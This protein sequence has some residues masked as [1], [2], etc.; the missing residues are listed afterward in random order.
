MRYLKH[1]FKLRFISL[2]L[3]LGMF[4]VTRH[5]RAEEAQKEVSNPPTAE[6]MPEVLVTAQQDNRKKSYKVDKVQSSKYTENL[7]DIPQTITVV[8][9]SVIQAQNATTLRDT[10]RNVPGISMQAGEGGTP[11]GDQF[12]IRGFSSRTDLYVDGVRDFGGYSRDPFNFEQVEVVKGPASSYAGRGSTG[13]SVNMVSKMPEEESFYRATAGW[14]TANYERTTVDVNQSMEPAG[15]SGAAARFN[16]MWQDSNV[17]GR[18]VTENERFGIAPSVAFGLDSDTRVKVGYF[19]MNQNNTPDY[20]VPWVPNT[21]NAL[22]EYRD[23][24]SPESWHK[25]YGLVDRDYDDTDTSML[26]GEIEHDFN[27]N[28]TLRNLTRWGRNSRDS[29]I[30]APRFTTNNNSTDIRRTDWKSRDQI[31]HV[32]ANQTDLTSLFSTFDLEHKLV[33]GVELVRETEVNHQRLA[34]GPASSNTSLENP[35]PNDSYRENIQRTGDKAETTAHSLALYGFDTIDLTDWL[36]VNGGI[37]WDY[38]RTRHTP[39][40][41]ADELDRLDRQF[42]WNAGINYKP[43]PYGSIYFGYG[44]AFNPSA[45]G[46]TLSTG[47]TSA[48]NLNSD[49]ETSRTFELGTKWDLFQERLSVNGAVFYTEKTNSRTQD[50]ADATDIIVNEGVQRVQGFEL[51]I[52]GNITEKW[53][54]FAAYTAL[55]SKIVESR[56]P[57]EIGNELSNTPNQSFSVWTTYQLPLNFE[58]GGG[59]QFVGDRYSSNANNRQGDSYLLFDLMAAYHVNENITLRLNGYNLTDQEYVDSVGGGHF[60][61][62]AGRSAILSTSFEF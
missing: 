8:P 19:Y 14:G 41:T 1:T 38:F 3:A 47:A 34:T 30:T 49:P 26:T 25:W 33:T 2:A 40:A 59:I 17:P 16:A 35:N 27:E 55:D 6:R 56:D 37:R 43:L 32:I 50:P 54:M 46:L 45:E 10:L 53:Q 60:I 22:A 48:N 58:V 15:L 62:G 57:N 51:G 31:D 23:E 28:F 21:N 42:S 24:A 7:I 13:G 39:L 29:I 36:S 44:T 12:S 20:G 52:S 9:Q 61:P 5:A 18:D 11:A 4:V